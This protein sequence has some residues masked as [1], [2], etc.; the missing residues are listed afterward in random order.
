MGVLYKKG[1]KNPFK[2]GKPIKPTANLNAFDPNVKKFV[3]PKN[4]IYVR[5]SDKKR[6]G[7]VANMVQAHLADNGMDEEY[8]FEGAATQSTKDGSERI[9]LKI[10][11]QWVTP[12][13]LGLS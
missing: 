4:K 11:G 10:N 13:Q 12:E 6:L 1:I 7:E 3:D 5:E 2:V 9:V 8:K